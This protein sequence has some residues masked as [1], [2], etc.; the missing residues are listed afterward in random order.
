MVPA[1]PCGSEGSGG[2]RLG[3]FAGHERQRF[4][5]RVH[6]RARPSPPPSR[7]A[8]AR[9]ARRAGRG[10]SP[11]IWRVIDVQAGPFGQPG[12]DIGDDAPPPR[13]RRQRAPARR[14]GADRRRPAA[15]GRDRRRG[16]ASRR[17]RGGMCS[18]RPRSE[19]MPPLMHDGQIRQR[20][21]SAGSTRHSQRRDVAVFLGRQ[22]L[23]P[24]LARMDAERLDAGRDHGV[25]KLV[26][27]LLRGP[28]RRRRC[29]ISPSPGCAP[30]RFIAA[31]HSPTS[32]GSRHQAGAEAAGLHPV[33]RAADIEVDL[34]I[35][36][37]ASPMRAASASAAGSRA[38][39]LQRDRM[40]GGVEAEQPLAIAMEHR[41][42]G[43]HLGIEQRAPRQ[44]AVE[45][46]AVPVGPVHHRRD[47]EA[48]GRQ[49]VHALERQCSICRMP[50]RSTWVP[51]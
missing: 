3:L 12:L 6:A 30:P 35:A 1:Q 22:A 9:P 32:A 37:L 33:G 51:K 34:V 14:R 4:A 20:A 44:Q 10:S 2:C 50:K 49:L 26:E 17:R 7:G 46:P 43:D 28:G 21:P 48:P 29:G 31:T 42:G 24:G 18:S 16:P 25:G 41:A 8:A 11:S 45:E 23:Q 19:A 40:L 38:A 39:E 36:E 15:P 13:N 5:Q 27:R 47:G